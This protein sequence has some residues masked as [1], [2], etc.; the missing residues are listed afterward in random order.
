MGRPQDRNNKGWSAKMNQLK[1]FQRQ[2][3]HC[4]VPLKD[5]DGMITELGRFVAYQRCL[6]KKLSRERKDDLDALGFTWNVHEEKWNQM[7]TNLQEF[8]KE[9]GHCN[10]AMQSSRKAGELQNLSKWV[11][12]QRRNY[13]KLSDE[14]IG[15]LEELGF[16][17]S[18][19]GNSSSYAATSKKRFANHKAPSAKKRRAG[20]PHT[21]EHQEEEVTS[22]VEKKVASED[23]A[24]VVATDPSEASLPPHEGAPHEVQAIK[25]EEDDK[26]ATVVTRP[27]KVQVSSN[28]RP[29]QQAQVTREEEGEE[30][31][32][33]D[34]PS[35]E[36]Q[37]P[38][39]E[40]KEGVQAIKEE[41]DEVVVVEQSPAEVPQR[42]DG[43][44]ILPRLTRIEKT[45][46]LPEGSEFSKQPT[47]HRISLLSKDLG[48][49]FPPEASL[50]ER[51]GALET[52]IGI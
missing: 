9:N 8:H 30:K 36:E 18:G 44:G 24:V 27:S 48:L 45:L 41:D 11:S 10:V 15:K 4:K 35:E 7:F 26:E 12:Y 38:V 25:E 46:G 28:E 22:Q 32:N 47:H 2:H 1:E 43:T 40:I 51:V 39:V 5:S 21:S 50:L 29:S 52:A 17:W 13:R 49:M 34:A 31:V 3:G 42:D 6:Q 37:V 23:E 14:R 16:I 33:V 20:E 19:Y